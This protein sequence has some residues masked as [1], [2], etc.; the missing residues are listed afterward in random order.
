[1]SKGIVIFSENDIKK[2]TKNLDTN[3]NIGYQYGLL[4]E[5]DCLGV[6]FNYYRDLTVDRDIEESSG[7]SFT[8]VLKP[9]GS[10]KNYGKIKTF[11]PEVK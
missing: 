10:T 6:D 3:K 1:M 4:Y 11:G 7:F 5:N 8:I 2:D 9:F